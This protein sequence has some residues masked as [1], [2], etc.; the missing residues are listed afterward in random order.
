[1]DL[2]ASC[3]DKLVHFRIKDLKDVLSQLGIS[4]QGKKQDLV[5]RV[6]SLLSK[7]QVSMMWQKK[8]ITKE[9][10][11]R[12]VDDT[13]RKMQGFEATSLASKG[14]D[15]SESS[16]VK[17]KGECDGSFQSNTKV[18]CPCGNSLETGSMIMCKEPSCHVWQHMSCVLIPEKPTESNLPPVPE[19]FYCE[20]CRLHRADP[21]WLS[22]TNLLIPVMFPFT[23]G[24]CDGSISMQSVEKTFQLS[25]ADRDLLLKREY[26]VQVWCMLLN[27]TV[28]FRM[29]W[30]QYA[31]LQ[32]NGI[33]V[34]AIIRP[35]SQLLGA[36]GRDDGPIITSCTK[37]GINKIS[38]GGCDARKF[39]MGVRI[40][41]QCTVEQILNLIPKESEGEKFEDA[42]A[43]VCRCVGGGGATDADND[44]D[45]EIVA[46]S[47]TVNLRC[48]MSSSRM[49]IAGRFKPCV[50]MGCF[51]LEVFVMM[52]QRTR[53]WQCPICLRN[54]SLENVIIDPYYNRIT[55]MLRHCL[56]DVTEIYVK[57]DGS[58]RVKT[59]SESEHRELGDLSQWHLPDATVC[60]RA[61]EN[62]PSEEK[63]MTQLE[64]GGSDG[65]NKLKLGIRK[66]QDGI[67]EFSR[68]GAFGNP[69][70]NIFL[71]KF[72]DHELNVIPMSSS[73]TG[74]GEDEELSVN[75]DGGGNF[76]FSANNSMELDS[77]AF[78]VDR[79]FGF[80]EQNPVA[81]AGNLEVVVLSDSDEDNDMLNSSVGGYKGNMLG[82]SG[83]NFS[84]PH[85]GLADAF[86]DPILGNGDD[87]CLG[88][89]NT[90]DEF[91]GMPLWSLPPRSQADP[92][93]QLF[94]SDGN[95]SDA[96][97][98]P[99]Y[100][101]I[102]CS[103]TINDY[104]LAPEYDIGQAALH[105]DPPIVQSNAQLNDNLVDNPLAMGRDDPSLQNFLPS[106]SLGAS[107]H[108]NMRNQADMANGLHSDDW[109]SL[110]LGG[111][112]AGVQGDS[113]EANGF[114]MEQQVPS[115]GDALASLGDGR[116]EKVSRPRQDSF[117]SFPRQKRSLRQQ[118]F[119]L[120]ND[121]E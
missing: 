67:W 26:D 9:E 83:I 114:S 82:S 101:D 80:A 93:F 112:A 70:A 92:D 89:L 30:P 73:A 100:G 14:Q 16:T 31:D 94:S 6:L 97:V 43:R 7:A 18:R 47:I 64:Q 78:N 68:P 28:P 60:V 50:H 13:Y 61:D 63:L 17:I 44:S 105:L 109:I 62:V 53:K 113:A 75:Q 72:K 33:P 10:V 59:K 116:S 20:L 76:D 45:I 35:V 81:V 77:V 102:N 42:L 40:V 34:R 79:M 49:K 99:P 54:Y 58:W 106:R 121:S 84:L 103:T 85:T 37:D 74:S 5:D 111:G 104:M 118:R 55:T 38:I 96:L 4:K 25:R 12:L 22:V 21:F 3:K 107:T 8:N 95:V 32:V 90:K 98:G 57:P 66:N 69:N 71:D 48:P 91:G 15:A 65:S 29:Q 19:L 24:P 120:S 11:V 41:K 108:S 27:D 117:S 110:R 23:S 39:C 56:E 46:D 2:V 87:S 51:D 86:E 115:G 119:F 36:N 1:M 52:N 88:L